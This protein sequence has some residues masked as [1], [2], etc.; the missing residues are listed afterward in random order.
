MSNGQQ[1]QVGFAYQ[2]YYVARRLL[3]AWVLRDVSQDEKKGFFQ[4]D[5]IQIEGT[6]GPE[7][8]RWDIVFW[9]H[10]NGVEVWEAK[11]TSVEADDRRNLYFR[12]RRLL[13]QSDAPLPTSLK[14]GWVI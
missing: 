1:A 5:R 2:S 3:A 11:N 4:I 12:A 9:S 8:P 6:V 14:I 7:S 10:G 13:S